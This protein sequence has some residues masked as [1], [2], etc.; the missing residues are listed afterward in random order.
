MYRVYRGLRN[1]GA[2]ISEFKEIY[3]MVQDI[4]KNPN[5]IYAIKR[6]SP[7]GLYEYDVLATSIVPFL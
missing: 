5:H 1:G 6:V 7:N 3:E 4:K 2:T